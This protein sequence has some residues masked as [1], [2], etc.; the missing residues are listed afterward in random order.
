MAN[1]V[2]SY[3]VEPNNWTS[4]IPSTITPENGKYSF[5]IN[6]DTKDTKDP[7]IFVTF[8]LVEDPKTMFKIGDKVN[9]KVIEVKDGKVSLSIKALKPNPWTEAEK[10]YNQTLSE[11]KIVETQ[12]EKV[13]EEMMDF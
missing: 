2:G 9:V 11:L 6:V 3:Y 7:A 5:N 8:P 12:Y 10:K 1:A 4:K 13:F